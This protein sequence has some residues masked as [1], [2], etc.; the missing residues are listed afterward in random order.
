M[1]QHSEQSPRWTLRLSES[2]LS[3]GLVE[4]DHER[5]ARFPRQSGDRV[6]DRKDPEQ[7]EAQE[8]WRK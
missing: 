4:Q 8:I 7:N 2:V 3:P 5:T 6:R 1:P